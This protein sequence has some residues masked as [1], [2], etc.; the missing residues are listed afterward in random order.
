MQ[1]PGNSKFGVL[2][3]LLQFAATISKLKDAAFKI[4]HHYSQR[5]F[6]YVILCHSSH[7]NPEALNAT[8]WSHTQSNLCMS[9]RKTEGEKMRLARDVCGC[10]EI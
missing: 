1:K 6:M 10:R 5:C 4:T 7:L 8:Q 2:V 9:L 3:D